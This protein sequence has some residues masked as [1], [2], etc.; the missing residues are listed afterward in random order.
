[1]TKTYVSPD[2]M[3]DLR[4]VA[5]PVDAAFPPRAIVIPERAA[6]LPPAIGVSGKLLKEPLLVLTAIISNDKIDLLSKI[7]SNISKART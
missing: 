1:M 4:P 7:K 2:L 6:L 5:R 3:K